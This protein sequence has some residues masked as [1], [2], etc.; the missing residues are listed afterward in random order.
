MLKDITQ[1]SDMKIRNYRKEK[2]T[3]S[4]EKVKEHY[5]SHTAQPGKGE[6]LLTWF[7]GE[8]STLPYLARLEIILHTVLETFSFGLQRCDYQTV[9]NKMSRV[10][11]SFAST[12]TVLIK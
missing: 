8:A 1:K 7:P 12:K 4:Q 11:H 9:A 6:Q 10:A 2:G 3:E 5:R